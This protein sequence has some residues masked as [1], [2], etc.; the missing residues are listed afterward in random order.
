MVTDELGYVYLTGDTYSSSGIASNAF[1]NNL[2]GM[3]NE[4][5][6]QFDSLGNRICGT[7][8]GA[9]HEEMGRVAVDR[10]GHVYLTGYTNSSSGIALFGFQNTFGGGNTDSY[11]AKFLACEFTGIDDGPKLNNVIVYPNPSTGSFIVDSPIENAQMVIYNA[12]GEIIFLETLVS[13][14]QQ[15][16]FSVNALSL[17]FYQVVSNGKLL[18]SGK[19]VVNK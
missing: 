14:K 1:Q 5:V 15:I 12:L 2:M 9:V 11:I 18:A 13:G 6:I 3:E 8:F 16:G 10:N 17:Y 19:L 7:Y 4:F